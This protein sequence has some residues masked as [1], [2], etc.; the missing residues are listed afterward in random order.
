[1]K[2]NRHKDPQS[3]STLL[4][5][6]AG[7]Q[8]WRKQL[9]RHNLFLHWDELVDKTTS[10][11]ARPLK[12]VKNVLWL[13]ITNSAW[14]QQFQFQKIQLLDIINK[15]LR[16]SRLQDIRFIL[17]NS[18]QTV[19]HREQTVHFIQPSPAAQESFQKQIAGIEN[20]EIRNA[21]MDLWYMSHSCRKD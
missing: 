10:S 8:G 21:L 20:E 6:L 15:S 9:D 3:V 16:L 17:T 5:Q 2:D 1:M 12:I 4:S 19:K 13:E 7:E 11:H 18:D 14:M